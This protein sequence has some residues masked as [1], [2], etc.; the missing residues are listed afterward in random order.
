MHR[1]AGRALLL[2]VLAALAVPALAAAQE[3]GE[4]A[5]ALDYTFDPL[6][7]FGLAAVIVFFF[8]FSYLVSQ[9]EY[10]EMIKEHFERNARE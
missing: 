6:T 10:R 1:K 9:Q 4:E 5:P 3:S 8:V 2:A 7:F